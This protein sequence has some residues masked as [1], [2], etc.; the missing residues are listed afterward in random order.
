ML[1][2]INAVIDPNPYSYYA[3]LAKSK[4][5][6]YDRS[7]SMWVA[8]SSP[9]VEEVLTSEFCLVR[10]IDEPVPNVLVGTKAG[11]VFRH[12]VRMNDGEIHCPL[13]NAVANSIGS[14]DINTLTEES[15]RWAEFLIN[16]LFDDG[17]CGW[18]TDFSFR[19]PMYVVGSLLGLRHE[20]LDK[21][22]KLVREL[23]RCL[24]SGSSSEQIRKG[25]EAAGTLFKISDQ[26]VLE[27]SAV[28]VNIFPM[29]GKNLKEFHIFD[30]EIAIANSIGLLF[31]TYEATAGLIGNALVVL[32]SRPQLV[33]RL[34]RDSSLVENVVCEVNRF[35]PSIQNTRRFS[36][37]EAVVGGVRINAGETILV[38]LA[39]ANRDSKVNPNPD[40]FDI[41]RE[42]PVSF[43]FGRGK[44]MCPGQYLALNIAEIGVRKLLLAGV[45]IRKLKNNVQYRESANSRIPLF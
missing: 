22:E 8:S 2:P 44:H 1:N 29:I 34:K 9:I 16:K 26:M 31:Q 35:D 11:Y 17:D 15:E 37:A 28:N 12:L 19:L 6:Y 38:I 23:V 18:I 25:K 43:T 27:T 36:A 41:H 32:A 40:D 7:L 30:D 33:E 45:E 21:T 24:A 4:P 5:F 39:A 13:K 14:V 20:V 3:D 42:N 10:P